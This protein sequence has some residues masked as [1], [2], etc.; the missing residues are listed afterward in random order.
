MPS[1]ALQEWRTTQRAEPDRLETAAGRLGMPD[2][3][4]RQQLVDA[5]IVLLAAH[6]QRYCRG[7]HDDVSAIAMD[8]VRPASLSIVL[9]ALLH[10]RRHL[11]RGN[12]SAS[13]LAADFRRLG[14]N[15]WEE[16]IRRDGRNGQRQRRL[17][18]LNAWRNAIAHQAFPLSAE[19][20]RRVAGTGRTLA[21]AR[22][23][24]RDCSSLARQLDELA[25]LRLAELVERQPW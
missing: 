13:A 21:W 22:L 12:A 11:D 20:A 23:W 4:L 25:G 24:R 14:M 5:Y 9:D 3:A 17:D 15:V 16:L 8:R 10:E 2:R 18:Q 7:L 6:F 19:N 1:R